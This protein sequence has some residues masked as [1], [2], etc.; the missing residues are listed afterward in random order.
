MSLDIQDL[1]EQIQVQSDELATQI[2]S[3][4]DSLMRLKEQF[5]KV[6]GAREMLSIVKQQSSVESD[7]ILS[8]QLM[9]T[10]AS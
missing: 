1:E 5:L 9:D 2:R 10:G 6:Q 4:E 3:T 8:E 7:A